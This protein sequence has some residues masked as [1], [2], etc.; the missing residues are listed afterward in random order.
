M[1]L[2]KSDICVRLIKRGN[3]KYGAVYTTPDGRQAYFAFRRH[4]QMFRNGEKTLSDAQRK[5]VA[6]WALDDEALVNLRREGV[7]MVGVLE[8]DTGDKYL[9]DIRNYFDPSKFKMLNYTGR[10]GSLQRHVP[11]TAFAR[12]FGKVKI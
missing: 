10:G 9:T 5:G 3:R 11:V 12:S 7:R 4:E 1:T 2:K 6:T 8:R